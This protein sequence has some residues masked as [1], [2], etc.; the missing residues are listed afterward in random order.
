[1]RFCYHQF[2]LFL[3]VFSSYIIQFGFVS[4]IPD[5]GTYGGTAW[6]WFRRIWLSLGP[7][8]TPMMARVV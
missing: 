1:M 4:F 3:L 6:Y 7:E 8:S 5:G 2:L